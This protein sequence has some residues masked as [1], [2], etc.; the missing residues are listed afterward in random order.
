MNVI[1]LLLFS[2]VPQDIVVTDTFDKVEVNHFYDDQGRHVFDQVI[3]YDWDIHNRHTVGAWRLVKNPGI[4][5]TLNRK[6]NLYQSIFIDN[7]EIRK[8]IAKYIVESWTQHD[9]ELVDREF[10]KKELRRE[11]SIPI[12]KQASNSTTAE[13]IRRLLTP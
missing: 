8:V 4:I 5:P 6:T 2:I 9:V 10:L 1:L 12:K 3:W 7:G 11:L 13:I